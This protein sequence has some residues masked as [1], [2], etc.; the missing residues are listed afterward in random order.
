LKKG[1]ENMMNFTGCSL[2]RAIDL[3]SL[4]VARIYGLNDRG[5]LAP[6]KRADLIMFERD[7]NKINIKK[8]FL[9]GKQVYQEEIL[10]LFDSTE[11]SD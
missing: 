9:S 7:G 4:N 10:K 5:I 8:T 1:V 3:A 11:I 2:T 6:G